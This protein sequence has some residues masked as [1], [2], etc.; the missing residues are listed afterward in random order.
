[1][2]CEC[3]NT[4]VM[5]VSWERGFENYSTVCLYVHWNSVSA[6]QMA[7]VF[8]LNKCIIIHP[9]T[10]TFEKSR[11]SL[12]FSVQFWHSQFWTEIC[13][14]SGGFCVGSA[15]HA[16]CHEVRQPRIHHGWFKDLPAVQI[17]SGPMVIPQ[18]IHRLHMILLFCG[19]D[20]VE[21]LQLHQRRTQTKR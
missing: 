12:T 10:L 20:R 5:Y 14:T 21:C 1:M 18:I 9:K 8:L 4:S 17:L 15:G 11:H 7:F 6:D 19:E 2:F 3:V 13:L 16:V